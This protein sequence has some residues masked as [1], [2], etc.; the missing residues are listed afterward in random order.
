MDSNFVFDIFTEEQLKNAI[1][2]IWWV[3]RTFC[4][5]TDWL[6]ISSWLEYFGRKVELSARAFAAMELKFNI[7]H[8]I[9]SQSNFNITVNYRIQQYIC[10]VACF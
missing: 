9:E 10:P 4:K 5:A 1:S 6:F 2:N 8:S 3:L 7:I